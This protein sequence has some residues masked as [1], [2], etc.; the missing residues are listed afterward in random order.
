MI[1]ISFTEIE[2]REG[3]SRRESERL[4]VKKCLEK[5]GM[6]ETLEHHS[7][8]APYIA[9]HPEISISVSHSARLCAVA[10]GDMN[11]G[12][13]GID[14]ED[15]GRPQLAK[16]S[17]RILSEEELRE[18]NILP[19]GMAKAWT[20]KEALYKASGNEKTDFIRDIKLSL[21][22]FRKA[23][24]YPKAES[25]NLNFERYSENQLFCLACQCNNYEIKTL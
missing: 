12:K 19:D 10:A 11:D 18:A 7:N 6:P 21:P 13:F 14:I 5:L 2:R 20:A 1:R 24:V 16:V 9:G 17:E 15:A 22:G 4:A 25:Y 8:G 23:T 3:E